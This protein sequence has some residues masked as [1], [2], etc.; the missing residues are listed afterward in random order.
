MTNKEKALIAVAAISGLAVLS[1]GA[2]AIYKY[3]K[4]N[5]IFLEG[6]DDDVVYVLLDEEKPRKSFW[7]KKAL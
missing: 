4:K 1:A 3:L 7:R 5:D 6:D 2:F